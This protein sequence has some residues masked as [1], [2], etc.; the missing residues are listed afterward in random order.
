MSL[1]GS[2]P[3][4]FSQQIHQNEHQ[5]PTHTAGAVNVYP[6]KEIDLGYFCCIQPATVAFPSA[7]QGG[8]CLQKH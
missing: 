8:L 6:A 4:F 5:G 1:P 7:L 3:E 2:F